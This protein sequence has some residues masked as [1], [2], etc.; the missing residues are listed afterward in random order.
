MAG[1]A[2]GAALVNPLAGKVALV[3]GATRGAGRGIAVELGALGATVLCT[4]RS[5][6]AGL[7]DLKRPETIEQTAALVTEAG[8]QGVAIRC[9]HSDA[10]QVQRLMERVRADHGGL[11]VLVNDIWGGESLSQWGKKFWEQDLELGRQMLDRAVW[12]HILTAHAGL[13][14]LRA[15]G[16]IAEITDGDGWYY[17]GNFF[18]DLAKTAVMRL[19]QNWASELAGDG[20]GLTS[21][22]LTPG[23]LRSEEMLAH[24]GVSEERWQDAVLQDANFAESETPHL[25]GRALA[26]LAADPHR[27]RFNGCALA[28]WTLME[29][30]GLS[31]IDGRRPHWGRWYAAMV[32]EGAGAPQAES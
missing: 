8:G 19:A 1:L 21:V 32:K 7:S 5:S 16:L 10:A 15:G 9:D 14:L 27:Q 28:S 29:E 18:Y 30:Y 31:D 26:H 11:D 4:G 3:A 2:G 6:R 12:T 20:R 22:S 23:F 24:F 13:P 17:R 25:I